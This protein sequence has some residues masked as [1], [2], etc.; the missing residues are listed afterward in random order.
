VE[1]VGQPAGYR[2]R[3]QL[4]NI[5]HNNLQLAMLEFGFESKDAKDTSIER[6]KV[7]NTLCMGT[8]EDGCCS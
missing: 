6:F 1:R 5:L 2:W 8:D 4:P 7:P 3:G